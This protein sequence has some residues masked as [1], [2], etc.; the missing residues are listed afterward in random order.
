MGKYFQ[1]L[2]SENDI[3]FEKDIPNSED[4]FMLVAVHKKKKRKA[5]HL[6]YLA[7]A[8]YRKPFISNSFFRY[9][10][11]FVTITTVLLAI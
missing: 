11:L 1:Q 9:L 8:K 2:L 6:N 5:E 10:T 7:S 4:E 3:H